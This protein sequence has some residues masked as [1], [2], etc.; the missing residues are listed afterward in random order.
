MIPEKMEKIILLLK[1]FIWLYIQYQTF[2][3]EET[4][5]VAATT[6]DTGSHILFMCKDIECGFIIFVC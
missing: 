5:P 4:T 6:P 2:I 1:A 3:V